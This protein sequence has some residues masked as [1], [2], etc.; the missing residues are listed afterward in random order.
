MN[1]AIV[2][3]QDNGVVAVI[4]PTPDAVAQLGIMAIA[5]K[6]VPAGKPIKIVDA[7]VFDGVADVPQEAWVVDEA[8]LNDGVGADYGE[9][10]RNQVTDWGD[11]GS[12]IIKEFP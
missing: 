7:S 4:T 8:A 6:D 5:L 9:G 12:P 11:D 10:S 3:V 2:Y 1:Q